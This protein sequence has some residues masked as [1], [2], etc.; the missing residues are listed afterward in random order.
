M[1]RDP[2][3]SKEADGVEFYWTSIKEKPLKLFY[4]LT[5]FQGGRAK[6]STI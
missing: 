4:I 2:S 3:P 5:D 1:T 6:W